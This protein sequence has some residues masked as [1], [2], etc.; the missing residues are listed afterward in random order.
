MSTQLRLGVQGSV[1][2]F[3]CLTARLYNIPVILWLHETHPYNAPMVFVQPTATMNIKPGQH[4]D[5]TGN[6]TI[7]YLTD[8]RQVSP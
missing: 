1:T 7:P 8:W 3:I 2:V 5:R 4:V 6:V